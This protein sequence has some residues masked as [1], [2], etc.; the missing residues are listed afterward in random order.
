MSKAARIVLITVGLALGIVVGGGILTYRAC[1]TLVDS[2][3]RGG[4]KLAADLPPYAQRIVADRKLLLDGEKLVAFY[5]ET[6]SLDGSELFMLTDRRLVHIAGGR[7][8]SIPL[9]QIEAIDK[10][11]SGIEGET[12]LVRTRNAEY[13]Q[14]T[15]ALM[16]GA[17]I[18]HDVLRAEWQRHAAKPAAPSR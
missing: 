10:K 15:I 8:Q 14:V 17:D 6:I 18:F 2:G 4:V 1:A 7:T 5:D 11:E 13:M 16:N 3:D 9:D 12:L